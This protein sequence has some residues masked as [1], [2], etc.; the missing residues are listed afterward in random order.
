MKTMNP[1]LY[2]K[3][4]YY[5]RESDGS[6]HRA[7]NWRGVIAKV[8]TYRKLRGLPVGEIASEV[9]EQAC[10]RSPNL[11]YASGNAPAVRPAVPL[12]AKVL[13]WLYGVLAHKDK[14]LPIN[15]VNREEAA[16]RAGVCARC[17]L[18]TPLGTNTCSACREA[19]ANYR[20]QILDGKRSFDSRLGGCSALA[21]DLGLAVHLDQDRVDNQALPTHCWFRIAI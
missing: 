19:V 12:K 20:K 8:S 18:N 7:K 6:I 16:E 15:L 4:G 9:M 10:K 17:P 21:T 1:N 13:Q 14:G 5:F 2:P 3:E 11:C